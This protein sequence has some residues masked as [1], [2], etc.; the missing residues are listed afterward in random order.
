M[1]DKV[2]SP[3]G[4]KRCNEP[5]IQVGLSTNIGAKAV[6]DVGRVHGVATLGLE[7]E[8]PVSFPLEIP[9]GSSHFLNGELHLLFV[10]FRSRLT[11]R[12]LDTIKILAVD[13][14]GCAV[15]QGERRRH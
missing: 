5:I 8:P 9:E 13:V 12:P 1:C 10:S 15:C 6:L 2:G 11:L 14:A 3:V 7:G 4:D